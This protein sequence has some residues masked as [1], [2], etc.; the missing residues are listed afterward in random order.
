MNQAEAKGN[1]TQRLK[2]LV[3]HS[4]PSQLFP[5]GSQADGQADADGGVASGL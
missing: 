5:A 4:F 1:N 3:S 2:L